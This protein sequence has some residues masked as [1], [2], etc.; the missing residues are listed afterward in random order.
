[1]AA[2]VI[3]E[4]MHEVGKLAWLQ[5]LLLLEISLQCICISTP[6]ANFQTKVHWFWMIDEW[7]I[8]KEQRC[9]LMY[10]A[11]WSQKGYV[12]FGHGFKIGQ[13]E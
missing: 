4:N 8:G 9:G 13:Q 6:E 11:I 10:D 1:M 2:N 7:I 5:I 3:K 12:N